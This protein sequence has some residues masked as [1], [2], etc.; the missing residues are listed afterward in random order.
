MAL[1]LVLLNFTDQGIRAVHDTPSRAAAFAD[2]AK[3]AG[4]KV[5]EQLWCIGGYDGALVVEAKDD[6][7]VTA[8]MLGLCSL[9]NVRTTTLR[10]F[11]TAAIKSLVKKMPKR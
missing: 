10:A 9:G 7:T 11:D 6:E 4:V 8:V 5:R 3:K 2:E 1:Y